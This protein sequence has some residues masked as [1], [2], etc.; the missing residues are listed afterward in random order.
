MVRFT[1][2]QEAGSSD[3]HISESG[4]ISPT[5]APS[6]AGDMMLAVMQR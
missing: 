3:L 1:F 6:S 2:T 5:R 4:V